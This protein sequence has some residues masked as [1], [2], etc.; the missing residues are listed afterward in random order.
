MAPGDTSCRDVEE[1][2]ANGASSDHD[3]ERTDVDEFCREPKRPKALAP[4]T[5]RHFPKKENKALLRKTNCSFAKEATSGDGGSP[6]TNLSQRP[7]S[8][9][10][11]HCSLCTY[12]NNSLLPYCEMCESPRKRNSKSVS[13]LLLRYVF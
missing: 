1:V 13:V 9:T 2:L 3:L 10:V 11:W 5:P 8:G 12:S 7:A 4:S 6:L